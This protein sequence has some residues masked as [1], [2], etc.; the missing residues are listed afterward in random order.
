MKPTPT[1][2]HE[3]AEHLRHLIGQAPQ[4]A[5]ILGSGL[6]ALADHITDATSLGAADSGYGVAAIVETLRAIKAEG[7]QPE[8]SLKIVITDGHNIWIVVVVAS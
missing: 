8:N 7:R 6:G 5:I 4:T 2:H 1:P 3:A